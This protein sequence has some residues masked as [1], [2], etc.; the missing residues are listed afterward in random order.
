MFEARLVQGCLLKK[1][2]ETVKDLLLDEATFECS[3][4]GIQLQAMDHSHVSLMTVNMRADGFDKFRC[5][6]TISM[7]VDLTEMSKILRNATNRDIITMKV[8]YQAEKVTFTF[9]SPNK[10][11]VT[12]SRCLTMKM[13]LTKFDQG[14][15]GIPEQ[16]Y[17]AMIKM[18]SGEFQSVV[19][20]LSHFGDQLRQGLCQVLCRGQQ[21]NWQY[22]ACP[23][24]R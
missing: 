4:E 23:V 12:P 7:R 17:S 10:R 8:E 24:Q 2:L 5:E 19:R 16:N 15:L 3:N 11:K 1:V 21:W 13:K 20:N 14:L 18:P 9:E 22:Q 6:R